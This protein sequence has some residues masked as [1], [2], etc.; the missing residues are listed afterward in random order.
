M[1]VD[2]PSR[3]KPASC[4]QRRRSYTARVPESPES[5]RFREAAALASEGIAL[6]RQS[7]RRRNPD[8]DEA[9]IDRLLAEWLL[10]RPMDAP[11][12]VVPA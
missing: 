6:M 7:L 3:P 11:G 1:A 4:R 5:R 9:E 10:D 12:R 2:G 8:A